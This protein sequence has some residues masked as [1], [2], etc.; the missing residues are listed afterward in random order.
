M[1][2]FTINKPLLAEVTNL[3]TN[4]LDLNTAPHSFLFA[5]SKQT[6]TIENNE[7]VSLTINL[8]GDGQATIECVGY[9]DITVS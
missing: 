7:L 6:L 1:A 5:G 4:I 3:T 2:A 9:G 8:L